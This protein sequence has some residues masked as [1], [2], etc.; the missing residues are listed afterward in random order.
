MEDAAAY[1]GGVIRRS[2][3]VVA[4]GAGLLLSGCASTV[5]LEPQPLANTEACAEVS[6]RLPDALGEL[7]R[8]WTDAQ[9][10]AAWGEEAVLLGCGLAELAPTT[11][12]CVRVGGVDWVVNDEDFPRQTLATYGRN[13]A[14]LVSVDT[15]VISGGDVVQALSSAVSPLEVTGACVDPDQATPVG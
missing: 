8:Q 15:R 2:L 10:T 12:Q 13:P 11:L 9:A 5:H 1:A 6:V 14:V 7:K 3:T 4:L